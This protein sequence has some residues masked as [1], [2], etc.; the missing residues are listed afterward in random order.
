MRCDWVIVFDAVLLGFVMHES[1]PWYQTVLYSMARMPVRD[2]EKVSLRVM[3]A[4]VSISSFRLLSSLTTPL[5]LSLRLSVEY[6]N[7]VFYE[8]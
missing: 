5:Q 3:Q 4:D 7:R 1:W 2:N 8:K 6:K